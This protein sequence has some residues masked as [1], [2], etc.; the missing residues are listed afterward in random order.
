M[1]FTTT[2]LPKMSR[3]LT[4]VNHLPNVKPVAYEDNISKTIINDQIYKNNS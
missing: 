3:N 2:P 1:S 4:N